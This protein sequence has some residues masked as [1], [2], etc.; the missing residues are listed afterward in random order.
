MSAMNT[1]DPAHAPTGEWKAENVNDAL[2]DRDLLFGRLAVATGFVDD[3]TL[4]AAGRQVDSSKTLA[5][6]LV[7]SG[8]ITKETRRA[9]EL[10]LDQHVSNHD[11]DPQQSLVSL[12]SPT[13]SFGD[14]FAAE[15][16]TLP[17][18]AQVSQP[19]RPFLRRL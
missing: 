17:P 2:T 18:N 15:T 8:T 12:S 5:E 10:L 3:N 11:D 16:L 14:R 4:A 7:E 6:V 1:N 19:A 13:A 9:I